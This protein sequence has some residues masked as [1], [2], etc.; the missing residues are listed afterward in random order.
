M[1]ERSVAE[2]FAG[3]GLMRLGLDGAGWETRFAHDISVDKETLYTA[4]FGTAEFLRGDVHLL[5]ARQVPTVALATASF[6]CTDLSLAG[7][8]AGLG[9]KESSAFW[10]FVRILEELTQENR[11]PPLVLLENVTGFLTSRGGQDFR[12]ALLSLSRLGYAVDA[13]ILDAAWFVPQ[14]RQRLFVVGVQ[15]GRSLKTGS[16]LPL[17]SSLRPKALIDFILK[18][19][20]IGWSL[21]QLVGPETTTSTLSDVLEDLPSEHTGWWSQERV[22]YFENQ[23]SERHKVVLDEKVRQEKWSYGTAF[24]RMRQGRS[25]AE[26]RTDGLAGCLRTPKGGSARQILVKMGNGSLQVRL[27]TGREC[28]RLM[29]APDTFRLD[30]PENQALFAFGD[31]VCVPVVLWLAENYLNPV[32]QG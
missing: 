6:P 29:G 19:P 20:D 32:S 31:A 21:K 3:I 13:L 1:A 22:T 5:E 7:G 4:N 25:M 2:F 17:M 12:E 8:R 24:R 18:N 10:G 9:G 11:Q 23:L 15:R 28:A 14:S 30:V 27:L 26:L 16:A